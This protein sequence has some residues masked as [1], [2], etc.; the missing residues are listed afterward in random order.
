MSNESWTSWILSS[1]SE[2][3]TPVTDVPTDEPNYNATS[4]TTSSSHWGS[5][6]KSGRGGAG[7][8]TWQSDIPHNAEAQRQ[9][10][11]SE[12]QKAAAAVE[13]LERKEAIDSVPS[14]GYVAT[15]RGGAGNMTIAPALPQSN[16]PYSPRSP[17]FPVNR[18]RSAN[19]GRGGAG[20][21]AAGAAIADKDMR[22]K[23]KEERTV[24]AGLREKIEQDV[25][26]LLQPPQGA[27]LAEG[28]RK[29]SGTGR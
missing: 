9:S 11:L 1:Y 22:D 2:S 4:S 5:Y 24:A 21:F 25:E 23:E 6:N 15:G 13:A 19:S 8:F 28:R 26:N 7:N 29:E 16:S 20:N 17:T 3:V 14:S 27:L 10:S 12:R 18:T